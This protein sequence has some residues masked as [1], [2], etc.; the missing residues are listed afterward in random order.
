MSFESLLIAQSSQ[1]IAVFK[2]WDL[3]YFNKSFADI[4]GYTVE[5]LE[6]LDNTQELFYSEDIEQLDA[7][8]KARNKGILA[9]IN[10][11][12]KGIKQCGKVI[13]L[14]CTITPSETEETYS[15]HLTD[16]THTKIVHQELELR[17][18]H[19]TVE[20]KREKETLKEISNAVNVGI[21]RLD[22]DNNLIFANNAYL[23]IFDRTWDD[24]NKKQYN[25]FFHPDDAGKRTMHIN[26]VKDGDL[27]IRVI[28]PSGDI[29]YVKVS[30]TYMDD[31][32]IVGTMIDN[33]RKTQL[34][35]ELHQL[36]ESIVTDRQRQW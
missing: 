17:L 27:E 15:L 30:Y 7:Y 10:Y 11:E 8:N 6:N 5:E 9:P 19:K 4:F 32:T 12:C 35:P 16:V 29:R 33:T 14:S 25:N 36:K 13:W 28:R 3:L 26:A 1:G 20:L 24:L 22:V 34:L 23:Q 21:W 31:G 2:Q 18:L